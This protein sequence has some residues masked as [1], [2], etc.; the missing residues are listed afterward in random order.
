MPLKNLDRAVRDL[1]RISSRS[2][3]W[4]INDKL[5]DELDE[6][7]GRLR[8][9]DEIWQGA[10]NNRIARCEAKMAEVGREKFMALIHYWNDVEGEPKGW[11][12]SEG[13][14]EIEKEYW[15]LWKGQHDLNWFREHGKPYD[16]KDDPNAKF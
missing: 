15:R 16:I 6:E 3:K 7:E 4:D 13:M 9:M 11:S 12:D 2:E 1:E 14:T 8:R 10:N 5:L